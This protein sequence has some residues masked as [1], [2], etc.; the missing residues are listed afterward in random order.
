MTLIERDV[1]QPITVLAR[2][3]KV[4]YE[5]N[6]CSSI[7]DQHRDNTQ[8]QDGKQLPMHKKRRN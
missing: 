6:V 7:S 5:I 3:G 2:E 8:S 4:V 1:Y